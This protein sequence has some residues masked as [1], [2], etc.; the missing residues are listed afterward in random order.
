MVGSRT[1]R[2]LRHGCGTERFGLVVGLSRST[3]VIVDLLGEVGGR[4]RLRS[5]SGDLQGLF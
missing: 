1:Q 5:P 4:S 3:E 2:Y